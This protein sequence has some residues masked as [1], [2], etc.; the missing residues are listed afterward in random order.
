MRCTCSAMY[1]QR[2]AVS[3]GCEGELEHRNVTFYVLSTPM[4]IIWLFSL[5]VVVHSNIVFT[6]Y[7][8]QG[9][10]CMFLCFLLF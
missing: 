6:L 4:E 2:S 10:G 1:L 5:C 3:L 9:N 8:V 7:V